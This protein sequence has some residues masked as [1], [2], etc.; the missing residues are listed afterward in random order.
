M[1]VITHKKHHKMKNLL[2]TILF[3]T[4]IHY[5]FCAK[6]YDLTISLKSA[7]TKTPING[8]KVRCY[9]DGKELMESITNKNGIV[10]FKELNAKMIDVEILDETG[11]YQSRKA[12]LYNPKKE[13]Q[14]KEYLIRLNIEKELDYFNEIDTKYNSQ[15]KIAFEQNSEGLILENYSESENIKPA[16]Y[17]GGD[18]QLHRDIA[19]FIRYPSDCKEKNIQGIVYVIFFVQSNGKITN[20]K[21]DK[22]VAKALDDEAIRTIRNLND[23]LP[24]TVDGIPVKSKVQIPIRF[25]LR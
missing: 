10:I 5:G 11:I 6:T 19:I 22:S 20:V 17:K 23:W 4:S 14:T 13:S 15:E 8:I 12:Y 1:H 25:V 16:S 24:G 21:I 3:L 9:K 2:I 18:D 7:Y